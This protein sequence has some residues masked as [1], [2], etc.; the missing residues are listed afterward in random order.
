[1]DFLRAFLRATGRS[2]HFDITLL[3]IAIGGG[4]V[5]NPTVNNY[6]PPQRTL[7]KDQRTVFI[8]TLNHACPFD[9]AVHPIPGNAESMEYA[10][11]LSAAMMP[12]AK[13]CDRSF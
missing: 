12:V 4:N 1:M 2:S 5:I 11:Q 6:T 10:A 3:N 9:V 13:W 7:S 8:A